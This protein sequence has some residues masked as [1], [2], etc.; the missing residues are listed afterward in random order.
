MQIG[1]DSF[2]AAI[3][4]PATGLTVTPVDRMLHLLEEI[5]LADRVALDVFGIGEHHRPEFLDSAPAVILSAA[6]ARTQKIRLTSAVTVLSASDPVRVFQEFATLDLISRGRAEIV[7]GRGSFIESYPLFGLRLE[8][9]DELFAEKLDLLLKI[10]ASTEVHWSGKHRAPLTGQ[11]IYPRPLQN[12]LPIWVGVGGTPESFVR[13]GM[14]GIPLMVAIIGGEPIRFRPLVDLYR[15]AGRRA[16]HSP[17][18]LTVGLHSIGFLADTTDEAAEIFFP[19][20]AHTFND[21][22]KER[23]WPATTRAQF[24][25]QRN[26]TGAL[27]IG[28]AP[29]VAKKILYVNEALGGISR[30]TFQMGVSTLPHQKMLHAIEI[31]GTQVAPIVRDEL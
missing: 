15:E 25:A 14:L 16:G 2:A 26:P 10:R 17:Q 31:L 3:S 12:P 9:Y 6:A 13:A 4:D 18:Q 29:T 8:D 27:L 23:G 5:E 28:D 11:S 19:G 22:G 20:Y 24:D 21:I 7:A 1:I 30:I